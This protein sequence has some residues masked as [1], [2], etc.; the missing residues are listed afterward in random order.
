MSYKKYTETR[1]VV[2]GFGSDVDLFWVY[3]FTP[4]LSLRNIKE[5]KIQISE[6][7]ISEKQIQER[8]KKK[9]SKL[10]CKNGNDLTISLNLK[11]Y[12]EKL[13]LARKNF[14]SLS[15][16]E[17]VETIFDYIHRHPKGK[18]M[19]HHEFES[20]L[21]RSEEAGFVAVSFTEYFVDVYNVVY[22]CKTYP[23]KIALIGI[24]KDDPCE[25]FIPYNT[26]FQGKKGFVEGVYLRDRKSKE[27]Y[28]Y[29]LF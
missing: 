29:K 6:F 17:K 28:L 13:A 21:L 1:N 24:E 9:F 11:E 16:K 23:Y 2:R 12:E 15:A 14:I 19:T 3:I 10:E 20:Y 25:I 26:P 7:F 5:I 8:I 27:I 4:F 22:P 18:K